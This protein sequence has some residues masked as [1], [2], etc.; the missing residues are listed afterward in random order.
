MS[1]NI[2]TIIWA[3]TGYYYIDMQT[4]MFVS[5]LDEQKAEEFIN[6]NPNCSYIEFELLNDID[7]DL[8][9]KM[10]AKEGFRGGLVNYKECKMP[11]E[12]LEEPSSEFTTNL[13]LH[14]KNKSYQP[15][16]YKSLYYFFAQINKEGYLVL[17]SKP[18]KVGKSKQITPILCF[19][20]IHDIDI[21]LAKA[22]FQSQYELIQC[23]PSQDHEYVVNVGTKNQILINKE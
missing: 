10:F 18:L 5:F 16:F 12:L 23:Y 20:S 1:Q 19:S 21:S 11:T 4:F 8:L 22:L 2:Y 6:D 3:D 7:D 17:A 13:M 15:M 14:Y 9:T